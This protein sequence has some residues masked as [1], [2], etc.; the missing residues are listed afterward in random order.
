MAL[1]DDI[2]ARL[3]IVDVVSAYV[4]DL[5][6][7]GRNFVARCPFHQERTPSF[8]VFP[9]RQ[10]WRCFGACATGG[11]VFTFIMRAEN[12]DFAAAL[13][14]LAQR[15]GISLV[16]RRPGPAPR[17]PLLAVNE[18]ALRFFQEALAAERGG[19]ARDYLR[20]RGV[21]TEAIAQFGLGYSPSGGDELLRHMQAR[22]VPSEQTVLAGL[23]VRGEAGTLRDLFRGRLMFAIRDAEGRVVG[24]AGRTLDD[25]QPKYLN[26]PQ[27]DVFDKGRLLYGLD[28]ARGA[29]RTH[30]TIRQTSGNWGRPSS[31]CPGHSASIR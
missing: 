15:A 26:S 3:D 7:A 1:S 2:K 6:K 16:Q 14:L 8:V 12:Q 17:H 25:S 29:I 5:K 23:A 31:A 11:D 19:L 30:R 13:K 21:G 28:R 22:N 10:S 24:F 9:E 4:P 18:Q 27:T 20:Q